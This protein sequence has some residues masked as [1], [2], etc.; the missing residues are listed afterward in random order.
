MSWLDWGVLAAYALLM[1]GIGWYYARQNNDRGGLPRR[2]AEDVAGAGRPLLVLDARQHSPY[3][4]W[5]GKLIANGPMFL[6]QVVAH[7]LMY[8]AVGYGLIPLLMRQPVTSAY[9][10]LEARLGTGIRKAGRRRSCC[11][12][13]AGWRRSCTPRATSS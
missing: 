7:P 13:W 1:L 6:T 3:L 10:I 9:E 8:L 2:R 4:A 11:C 5:P 12:G